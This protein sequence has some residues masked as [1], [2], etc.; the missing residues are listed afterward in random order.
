MAAA[1]PDDAVRCQYAVEWVGTKLRWGLAA[2][3]AELAALRDV[4]GGCPLGP[5][6]TSPPRSARRGQYKV[7]AGRGERQPGL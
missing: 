2:D 3:D 7:P 5:W 1:R 6:R 4:A